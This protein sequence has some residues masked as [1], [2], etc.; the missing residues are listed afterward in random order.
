MKENLELEEQI[1]AQKNEEDIIEEK[2]DITEEQE[3]DHAK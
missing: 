3:D 1:N 2:Q